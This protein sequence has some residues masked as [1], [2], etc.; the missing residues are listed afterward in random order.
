MRCDAGPRT[1]SPGTRLSLTCGFRTDPGDTSS[2][3]MLTV[4]RRI[5][6][7]RRSPDGSRGH[8]GGRRAASSA[9]R[10][11]KTRPLDGR[12]SCR[13]V[14][15]PLACLPFP[16]LPSE[17]ATMG[18]G[19]RGVTGQ[20]WGLGRGPGV[21]RATLALPAVTR[22]AGRSCPSRPPPAGA[23]RPGSEAGSGSRVPTGAER[24]GVLA[25]MSPCAPSPTASGRS[26]SPRGPRWVPDA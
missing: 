1:C 2:G 9:A 5:R 21:R 3:G 13:R 16:L 4:L 12:S 19:P 18:C 17:S 6:K 7:G 23:S 22:S 24:P 11:R 14:R 15:S 25:E 20:C 10:A 8:R 26:V